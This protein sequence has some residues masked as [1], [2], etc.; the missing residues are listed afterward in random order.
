MASKEKC[1]K[2]I[3]IIFKKCIDKEMGICY[4]NYIKTKQLHYF[5]LDKEI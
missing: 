1:Y 4:Y 3:K 2:K 5:L